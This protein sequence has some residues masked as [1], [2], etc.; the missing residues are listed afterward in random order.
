MDAAD[1]DKKPI[2][3]C[4]GFIFCAQDDRAVVVYHAD[5]IYYWGRA[6]RAAPVRAAVRLLRTV[7]LGG[8]GLG[9]TTAPL[10][11]S[12]LRTSLWLPEAPAVLAADAASDV[13]AVR[14]SRVAALVALVGGRTYVTNV[15]V[16]C[17]ARRGADGAFIEDGA[18]LRCGKEHWDLGDATLLLDDDAPTAATLIN[19]SRAAAA[20]ATGTDISDTEDAAGA[21]AANSLVLLVGTADGG[22]ASCWLNAAAARAAAADPQPTSSS[23]NHPRAWITAARSWVAGSAVKQLHSEPVSALTA[24]LAA[25]YSTVAVADIGQKA[26]LHQLDLV[27][28]IATRAPPPRSKKRAVTTQTSREAPPIAVASAPLLFPP[29]RSRRSRAMAAMWSLPFLV[30]GLVFLLIAA[31]FGYLLRVSVLVMHLG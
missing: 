1:P 13:G 21:A 26:S 14:A 22:V 30:R 4:E 5:A 6:A 23:H 18:E 27:A 29:Y 12:S 31:A 2:S 9:L 28:A 24:S 19:A 20:S 3:Q 8:P 10:L 17:S 7:A 15:G 11:R 16:E 25:P